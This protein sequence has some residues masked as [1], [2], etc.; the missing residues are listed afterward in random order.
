VRFV[1][2]PKVEVDTFEYKGDPNL[3]HPRQL[4]IDVLTY[5]LHGT[6]LTTTIVQRGLGEGRAALPSQCFVSRAVWGNGAHALGVRLKQPRL[7]L[8]SRTA[9]VQESP[10]RQ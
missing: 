8:S 4:S 1:P 5:P 6:A 3:Q 10:T 2:L 9:L 7:F